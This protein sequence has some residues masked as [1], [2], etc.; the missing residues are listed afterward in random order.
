MGKQR[1]TREDPSFPTRMLRLSSSIG[2]GAPAAAAR[3]AAALAR[4]S[5]ALAGPRPAPGLPGTLATHLGRCCSLP[6]AAQG[7]ARGSSSSGGGGGRAARRGW[8]VDALLASA[9]GMTNVS[10]AVGKLG[11]KVRF[12]T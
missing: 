10:F 4:P 8:S 2:A 3:A 5:P 6:A 12:V 1:A 11:A 9:A 7:A